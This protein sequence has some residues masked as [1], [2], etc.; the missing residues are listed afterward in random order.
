M[1][2]SLLLRTAFFVAV[3]TAVARLSAL[4]REM[5]IASS[6]GASAILDAY[7]IAMA[8]PLFF[9]NALSA[10]VGPALSPHLI[11]VQNVGGDGR[12]LISGYASRMLVLLAMA[13]F[14]IMAASFIVVPAFTEQLPSDLRALTALLS[15][16]LAPYILFHGLGTV[17]IAVLNSTGRF[18]I[19]A[20]IPAITPLSVLI[21]VLT[22]GDE[23]RVSSI[24]WGTYAGSAFELT[25]IGY[26]MRRSSNPV[27]FSWRMNGE[28]VRVLKETGPLFLAATALNL[29]PLIDQLMAAHVG[30]G[31][32]SVFNF[33]SRLVLVGN[34]IAMLALS[35]T[36][37]PLV[38]Q[39]RQKNA[40]ATD[41]LQL[42]GKE[43]QWTLVLL[44]A[45]AALG[46]LVVAVFSRELIALFFQRGAM[47]EFQA[48]RI[49]DVQTIFA[50]QL[51][52]FVGFLFLSRVI[53][54][55][56]GNFLSAVSAIAGAVL[57]G[58]LNYLLLPE[59]GLAGIAVATIVSYGISFLL[60]FLGSLWKSIRN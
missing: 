56:D 54:A 10:T 36:V 59:Y 23:L 16:A 57:N 29:T 31:E 2:R 45:I 55:F 43:V 5:A 32:A 34:S 3:L 28:A 12:E 6:F 22:F 40:S 26:L 53:A 24:V 15:L 7:L 9:V 19:P 27:S 17:W 49:A 47:T 60:L 52:L 18:T 20:I 46:A 11:S 58:F 8:V 48:D 39:M 25:L 13:V 30:A 4:A 35:Q 50:F 14:L 51:P 33:G 44:V 41:G 1:S 21:A 38:S 37:T 42:W